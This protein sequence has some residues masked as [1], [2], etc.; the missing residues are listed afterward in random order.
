ME[1]DE[2]LKQALAAFKEGT[3]WPGYQCGDGR[4]I[5]LGPLGPLQPRWAG[6]IRPK[7]VEGLLGRDIGANELILAERVTPKA[8]EWL[9]DKG[10]QFLDA[11]GNVFLSDGERI[12]FVTGRKPAIS[13]NSGAGDVSR[14]ASAFRPKGLCVVFALLCKRDLLEA[15]YREMANYAAVSVGT[16]S[17]VIQDLKRLG[18]IRFS[19]NKRF[20]ERPGELLD[21]WTV[22]FQRELRPRLNPQRYRVNTGGWWQGLE[23][24]TL[25]FRLGGEAG[26]AELTGYLLP[27]VITLYGAGDFKALAGSIHPVRD[28]SGNLE[29]LERFWGVELARDWGDCV[30][31]VLVYADLMAANSD[32]L[33]EVAE[34]IREKWLE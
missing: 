27:E 19:G 13:A 20:W 21:D 4:E 32:R 22:A 12:V 2:L 25:G 24:Q 33:R 6:E 29:V 34:I 9:R 26:A 16:V 5:W 14:P 15:S 30:H 10:V 18:Y 7:D 23:L 3:G 11:L 28:E 31:P 8:A 1:R 17:H